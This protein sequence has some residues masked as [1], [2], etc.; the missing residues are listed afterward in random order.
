MNLLNNSRHV[1]VLDIGTTGIKAIIFDDKFNIIAR[2]YEKLNKFFPKPGWVE[3]DPKE[4]ITVAKKVLSA[5]IEQSG[6]GE[7]DFLG[8]GVT[9]QRETTILWDKETGEAVCP[10]IVWEDNRTAEFCR[11]ID[12]K[13]G[14]VIELKTGLSANPYFSASKIWWILEN[15]STARGLLKN[16]RLLFGTVDSWALWNISKNKE[17]QTDFTNAARTLLFNIKTLEWDSE[18]LEIFGVESSLLPQV[19]S[20]SAN[21]GIMNK[22]ILGFEMPV[23]AICGD[24]QASMFAA[25]AEIG[26]TKITYGT[27]AFISQIIGRDF[28]IRKPFFT[29][30][31]VSADSTAPLYML[32]AKIEGCGQKVDQL[33]KENKN[34]NEFIGQLARQTDAYIKKLPLVPKE[35]ILDGGITQAEDII[36]IQSQ[37]SG[38]PAKRQNIFDGASLGMALLINKAK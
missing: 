18:L 14:R 15:V 8:L 26:T 33:L 13:F 17:R 27:G 22:D 20:S 36:K 21:F 38:A 9:N 6:L 31:A 11:E 28:L 2:A 4:F 32:E 23:L 37:I 5:V 19:L 1:L 24:Q 34:L 16:G 7:N 30:L 10:A 25:G 29:T 12:K 3:Q 35:I